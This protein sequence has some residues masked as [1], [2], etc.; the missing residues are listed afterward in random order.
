MSLIGALVSALNCSVLVITLHSVFNIECA[1]LLSSM[2]VWSSDVLQEMGVGVV[3]VFETP[4]LHVRMVFRRAARGG[5]QC[6]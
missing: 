1:P 3:S 5:G 6:Y 4:L 2:H